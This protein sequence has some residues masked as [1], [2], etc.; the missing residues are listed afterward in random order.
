[1]PSPSAEEQHRGWTQSQ[2]LEWLET[3][4]SRQEEGLPPLWQTSANH[5]IA[6][7]VSEEVQAPSVNLREL[8]LEVEKR[9]IVGALLMRR[10]CQKGGAS[11]LGVKPSAPHEKRKRLQLHPKPLAQ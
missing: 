1:M 11:R 5:F 7:Y 6:Q 2:L 9:I 10:G 4:T 3:S 8:I